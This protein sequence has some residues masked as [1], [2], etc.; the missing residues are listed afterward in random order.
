MSAKRTNE[1]GFTLVE[2]LIATVVLLVG[3]TAAMEVVPAAMRVN[4]RNR[5][6]TTGAVLAQRL[7][8]LMSVQPLTDNQIVDATGRFP[9]GNTALCSF[10]DA[11]QSDVV[12]GSPTRLVRTPNG[13]VASVMIDFTGN[14]PAGYSFL[15]QDPSDPSR[16]TYEVRWAV[17]TSVRTVGK[18]VNQVVAKR[19][20]I[21]VRRQGFT[22][23]PVFFNTLVTR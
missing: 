5:N 20:I 18:L 14:A 23:Q 10:G 16:T 7:R 22:G 13:R 3:I 11:A 1:Q 2:L 9:C 17:V 4:L 6:D 15:Y 8:D 12:V 21:G 19:V